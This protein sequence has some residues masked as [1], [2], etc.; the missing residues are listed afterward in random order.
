MGMMEYARFCGEFGRFTTKKVLELNPDVLLC[1]D[2]S[3]G[4][5]LNE[6][7]SRGIK[8]ATVFHVDVVD[9]FS[10]LYMRGLID[11]AALTSLYRTLRPLPWPTVLRLVF[12]NQQQ[13]MEKAAL[14][15]VPSE[16]SKALLHRCYPE[17]SVPIKTVGWGAPT[18]A[19]S[20]SDLSS[21]GAELRHR[22]QIP[23][24]NRILLT[25]SRL[26]PEK[27]QQRLLQA[28]R[29]A[30]ESRRMPDDVTVVIAGA[31][32]FMEGRRHALRLEKLASRLKTQ[33]VF[34]GH[35]GGLEKAA[36][37][38]TSTLFVVNSLHESYGLTTL[39][40]MQQGC[41]V[42]A[43]RS[44]GTSDTVTPE[45]GRLIHPGPALTERLWG[46]I[47][48]LLRPD[49]RDKLVDMGKKARKQASFQTFDKAAE[50]VAM[51][52]MTLTS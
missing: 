28:V 18:I 8:V 25:L 24:E 14:A 27:A 44:F 29:F 33:V 19:F 4:P 51:A 47:E 52:L 22:H 40:A 39:E 26:S 12:E 1:H 34:S 23:P 32:A 6:I 3:E 43:V 11:P 16:G 10:R 50:V 9:I 45:V 20:E 31:P 48:H 37:Y 7:V 13:V 5:D 42:V 35:V 15:I 36:W 17:S 30:E 38:R 46:N 2:I 49:L 41:P 21:V